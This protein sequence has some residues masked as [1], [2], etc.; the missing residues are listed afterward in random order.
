MAW[1]MG[2][3]DGMARVCVCECV[4]ECDWAKGV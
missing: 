1:L 2:C 3:D 4:C